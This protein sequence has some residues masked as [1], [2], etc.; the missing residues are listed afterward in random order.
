MLDVVVTLIREGV[1]VNKSGESKANM[2][3]ETA[4]LGSA[5]LGTMRL[6]EA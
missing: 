2:G 1:V 5:I 4:A 3:G 6:G